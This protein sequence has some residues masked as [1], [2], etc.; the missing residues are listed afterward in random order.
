MHINLENMRIWVG[1]GGL[2][3]GWWRNK[4]RQKRKEMLSGKFGLRFFL[5]ALHSSMSVC[6]LSP[7]SS[8]C[9]PMAAS[10]PGDSSQHI[11]NANHLSL[12][13]SPPSSCCLSTCWLLCDFLGSSLTPPTL[14]L[15]VPARTW[16]VFIFFPFPQ[17]PRYTS[18]WSWS[19]TK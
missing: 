11:H 12:A 7:S 19:L 9:L 17:P 18:H 13:L 5:I 4:S 16:G 2:K 1:G 15:T 8:A 14:C 6:S 10:S 3:W